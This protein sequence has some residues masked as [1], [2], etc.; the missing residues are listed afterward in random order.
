MI[1]ISSLTIFLLG[2]SIKNEINIMSIDGMYCET[3]E[4]VIN[5]SAKWYSQKKN[6]SR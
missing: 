5:P 1:G 6:T 3:E 2:L 4:F